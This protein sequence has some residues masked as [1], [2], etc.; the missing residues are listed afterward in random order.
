MAWTWSAPQRGTVAGATALP[1]YQRAIQRSI[2]TLGCG[3]AVRGLSISFAAFL[4]IAG[5]AAPN[6]SSATMTTV[7]FLSG[8]VL[9]LY[10]VVMPATNPAPS[11]QLFITGV[12][13]PTLKTER[14]ASIACLPELL[15]SRKSASMCDRAAFARL[16]AHMSHELRTPLNAI[17]GFSEMM[18]NEVLGPLG[19]SS[20]TAYARDIHASGIS[21]L[22]SAE[23]ALAITSLLTAADQQ[24]RL[25]VATAANVAFDALEFHATGLANRGIAT[26][27]TIDASAEILADA[28]AA[29]QLL[30]NLIAEAAAG[31]VPGAR[32]L[33][34]SR[35]NDHSVEIL[36]T[37]C[38]NRL[39]RPNSDCSFSMLLARTLCELTSAQ[40]IEDQS[41]ELNTTEWQIAVRFQRANQNDFFG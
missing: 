23:D 6:F 27:S 16:T 34:A 38:G 18:S 3:D 26:G 35:T 30:I 39:P 12:A 7:L 33:L 11:N 8:A 37:V 41:A 28:Q 2:M 13:E 5:A 14:R 21:L 4:T 36:V 40:L 19:S 32:L 25:A 22:K 17:I 9:L 29:R 1:L 31:A 20:Y 15:T 24:Q 10:V